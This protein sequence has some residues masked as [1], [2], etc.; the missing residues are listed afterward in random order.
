MNRRAF[1]IAFIVGVVGLIL[2][3]LYQRRFEVEA[4]GGEKVRVLVAIKRVE[5][6]RPILEEMIGTRDVPAAYIDDRQVREA[7]KSKILGLR[8]STTVREQQELVWSDF[9]SGD[10]HRDLSSL[11]LPGYRAVSIRA[12][13]DEAN[14]AL[15][16]P[17]D[18][19]DVIGVLGESRSAVVLL[20]RVLVLALGT[21]TSVD[22]LQQRDS[23]TIRSASENSLTLS[24][25]LP[26]AQVIALASDK[27]K[28]TVAVRYPEDQQ[29]TATPDINFSNILD[30]VQRKVI[31]G[32]RGPAIPRDITG[33]Q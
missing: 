25:T 18:Y 12:S 5:R 23:K 1:F 29:K 11:V 19:V 20:Q 6:G 21:E 33:G 4:S 24:L 27:G 26:E 14:V 22:I 3:L 7:D 13:R 17:G 16:R 10:E 30:P 28:L 2:L 32:M 31:G 9:A 8:L 15:I